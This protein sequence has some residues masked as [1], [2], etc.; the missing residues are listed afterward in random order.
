MD[1]RLKIVIALKLVLIY[2]LVQSVQKSRIVHREADLISEF[3]AIVMSC[4]IIK[5]RRVVAI[6]KGYREKRRHMD[7]ELCAMYH[8]LFWRSFGEGPQSYYGHEVS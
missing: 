1:G 4:N 2:A 6:I 7:G 5:V 8:T 3:H